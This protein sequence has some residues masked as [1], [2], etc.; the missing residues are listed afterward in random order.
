MELLAIGLV[1][2]SKGVRDASYR[3]IGNIHPKMA[4][5]DPLDVLF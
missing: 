5:E 3:Y 1:A 4:P 2:T